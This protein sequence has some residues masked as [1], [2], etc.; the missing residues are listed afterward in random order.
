V[1]Y[2]V[3]KYEQAAVKQTMKPEQKSNKKS[4]AP[5]SSWQE[6][7]M[8]GLPYLY[9]RMHANGLARRVVAIF[10]PGLKFK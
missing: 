9:S 4:S 6:I 2:A 8:H 5:Y 10:I 3:V 7:G 1:N